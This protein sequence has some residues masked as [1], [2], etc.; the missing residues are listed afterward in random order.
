MIS[1]DY[2]P[3]P[4]VDL[5]A[6]EIEE[7]KTID[8]KSGIRH[9]YV[10]LVNQGIICKNCGKFTAKVKDYRIREIKHS[11]D[12]LIKYKA[13]R[14]VC[15]ICNKSEIE[16][17]PFLSKNQKISDY[18]IQNILKELKKYNSTFSECA[19]DLGI[20]TNKV[21]EVFDGYV[22][23]P[24][25]KFREVLC[26]DEFYFS[27]HSSSKY[28]FIIV[29]RNGD[30]IDVLP[31]RKKTYLLTYFKNIPLE[32]RLKVKYVNMDM[33]DIYRYVVHLRFKNA[34]I[35]VDPFHS[36]KLITDAANKIRCK[37]LHRYEN[38]KE[39]DEYYLL[40]NYKKFFK[41]TKDDPHGDKIRRNDHFK[42]KLSN[43][44][45]IAK[46]EAIDPE[47][48]YAVFFI[49]YFRQINQMYGKHTREEIEKE[50]NEFIDICYLSNLSHFIRVANT[51]TDWKEEILNSFISYKGR[52]LSNSIAENRNN[53]VK[54][55][56]NVS[57]GYQNF[58]RCRN[59][60]MYVETRDAK[61]LSEKSNVDIRRH[62]KKKK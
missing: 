43:N 16:S 24:R 3:I 11:K 1:E 61:P 10:T 35:A 50:L 52:R 49:T 30:V 17:N 23:M 45:L 38:N 33:Y 8:T 2:K 32:E 7:L 26:V 29:A 41:R 58:K 39:S 25:L 59:R 20:S 54:K 4:G 51:L 62:H 22:Q 36:T 27:R 42:R 14:I 15:P 6:K 55:L 60:I 47:L 31:S 19:K 9:Y 18:A 34:I 28:A 46:I 40:K 44:E 48:Q 37:F 13:R 53:Y 57:N 12:I 56:L 5:K 21:I